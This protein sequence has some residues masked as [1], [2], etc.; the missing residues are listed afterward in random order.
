MIYRM[1]S[2]V[3]Y[4]SVFF[5]CVVMEFL[6]KWQRASLLLENPFHQ[7]CPLT[8]GINEKREEIMLHFY[9][10][11]PCIFSFFSYP[12]L[13]RRQPSFITE[14]DFYFL[15]TSIFFLTLLSYLSLLFSIAVYRSYFYSFYL[16]LNVVTYVHFISL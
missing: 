5:I 9:L 6:I 3:L 1:N 15:F 2:S 4:T 8:G 10:R 14:S 12:I 16:M 11:L 13:K 7:S